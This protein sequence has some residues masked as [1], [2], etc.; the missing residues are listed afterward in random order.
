MPLNIRKMIHNRRMKVQ[1]K[2][3]MLQ[4]GRL[5][6]LKAEA[7]KAKKVTAQLKE[8]KAYRDQINEAKQLRKERRAARLAPIKKFA[9]NVREQVGKGVG[10]NG[11]D[12]NTNNPF[13]PARNP[14]SDEKPAAKAK[15][16]SVTIR[17]E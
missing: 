1:E 13:T 12:L 10:S 11:L 6:E 2:K 8:E 5:M 14:F 16:K 3:L 9:K 7:D 4:E 15:T 17:L